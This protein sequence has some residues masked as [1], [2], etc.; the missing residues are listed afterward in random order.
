MGQNTPAGLAGEQ[1]KKGVTGGTHATTLQRT[2]ATQGNKEPF[3]GSETAGTDSTERRE[4]GISG[5]C[6]GDCLK[7]GDH[8]QRLQPH[9]ASHTDKRASTLSKP[10]THCH[11]SRPTASEHSVEG[12]LQLC[13]DTHP[14]DRCPACRSGTLGIPGCP[15]SARPSICTIPS[16]QHCLPK[17]GPRPL[18]GPCLCPAASAA[19]HQYW[20][21]APAVLLIQPML[22]LL[23]PP[24]T[25]PNHDTVKWDKHAAV[26][27][28]L[29]LR[30]S[31]YC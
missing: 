12:K 31:S 7:G 8:R 30:L 3:A 14:Q 24:K 9:R 2:P 22:L 6:G 13:C 25:P 26:Q 4:P 29:Q 5:V 11:A 21:A 18:H 10:N 1:K 19:A 20:P 16:Q 27:L 28:L 23:L 17:P 15:K